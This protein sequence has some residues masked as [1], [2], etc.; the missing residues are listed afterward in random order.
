MNPPLTF[1]NL[2]G[3]VGLLLWGVHM[4]Q[5]GVQRA[6]GAHLRS[7]RSWGCSTGWRRLPG[8]AAAYP[9]LKRR[10]EL[11]ARRLRG[12]EIS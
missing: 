3:P 6:F 9:I 5:T 1:L 11:L 12:P 4:V 10:G 2:A 7:W 8:G